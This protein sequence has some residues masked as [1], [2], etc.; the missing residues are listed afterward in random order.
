LSTE[1]IVSRGADYRYPNTD[2][3]F[4]ACA[5]PRSMVDG[6]GSWFYK[7][8]MNRDGNTVF[9]QAVEPPDCEYEEVWWDASGAPSPIRDE[10][11]YRMLTACSRS[12]SRAAFAEVSAPESE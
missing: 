10:T 3:D 6:N 2:L 12:D 7:S 1:G 4:Y 5:D 11:I 9:M 8:V